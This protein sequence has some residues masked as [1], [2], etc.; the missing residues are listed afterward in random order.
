MSAVDPRAPITTPLE[1]RRAL[2]VA[3]SALAEHLL[4][5]GWGFQGEG[6]PLDPQLLSALILAT[7]ATM[8]APLPD[9]RSLPAERLDVAWRDF[10]AQQRLDHTRD[11]P[12]YT[13][14]VR[15][16]LASEAFMSLNASDLS[17]LQQ[18]SAFGW[19]APAHSAERF[20]S[21]MPHDE[22]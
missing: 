5:D 6:N 21:G 7:F 10:F 8:Q 18:A 19:P 16:W 9:A 22:L 4:R 1:H 17:P 13:A 14:R 20:S 2:A 15:A 12:Q 11:L 3:A